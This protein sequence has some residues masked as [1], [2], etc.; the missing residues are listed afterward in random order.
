MPI[1]KDGGKKTEK[2]RK[3]C[4]NAIKKDNKRKRQQVDNKKTT[5]GE[6]NAEKGQKMGEYREKRDNKKD[7]KIGTKAKFITKQ[8]QRMR[9]KQGTKNMKNAKTKGLKNCQKKGEIKVK[10]KEIKQ[11]QGKAKKAS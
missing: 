11:R 6:I 10:K 5:K 4:K 2:A 3:R 9:M 1:K 8:N 7:D